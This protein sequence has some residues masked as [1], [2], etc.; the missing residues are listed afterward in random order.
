MSH[1]NYLVRNNSKELVLNRGRVL[2]CDLCP[3]LLQ[4]GVHVTRLY[5]IH[6]LLQLPVRIESTGRLR[7]MSH[8]PKMT[9]KWSS[10]KCVCTCTV[11]VCLGLVFSVPLSSLWLT[12]GQS[13]LQWFQPPHPSHH[14][15]ACNRGGNKHE[16]K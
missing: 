8:N 10:L 4:L 15:Y 13:H 1:S 3:Q 14:A 2:Q 5:E 7:L 6:L 9:F 16:V 11:L 12:Y